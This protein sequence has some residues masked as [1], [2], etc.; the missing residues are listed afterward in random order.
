MKMVFQ[1]EWSLMT[2]AAQDRFYCIETISFY[3]QDFGCDL[4]EP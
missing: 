4:D 1:H 3:Y 2:E